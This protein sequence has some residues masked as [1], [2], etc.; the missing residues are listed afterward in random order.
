MTT[1]DIEA[2]ARGLTKAQR[3]YVLS[4]EREPDFSG[5]AAEANWSDGDPEWD[6]MIELGLC[7]YWT[8]TL[9][10]LGQQVRAHLLANREDTTNEA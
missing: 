1:P 8:D 6:E 10:P 2:L 7:E 5:G 9:T 4:P 3:D